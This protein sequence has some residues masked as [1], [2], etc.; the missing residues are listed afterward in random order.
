MCVCV[1]GGGVSIALKGNNNLNETKEDSCVQMNY[2][3]VA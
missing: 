3:V 1:W 2:T